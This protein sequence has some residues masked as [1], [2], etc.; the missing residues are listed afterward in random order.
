MTR[1]SFITALAALFCFV[2]FSPA[3]RP[4]AAQSLADL[5]RAGRAA[6]EGGA[7][8][9]SVELKSG[10][11]KGLPQWT[12]VL[13][14]VERERVAFDRCTA[15]AT[16]CT[17]AILRNWRSII[18]SAAKLPRKDRVKAVNDFFN[19]WPYKLDRELYGM[20]EYWATPKEFMTRSGDCEDYSIAKYFALRKLGFAKEELR[21]VILMDE[22]RGIGHSVLAIYVENDILILDS[23]SNLIV[24]HTRYKQYIPQYSMNET[25]RWAHIGGFKKNKTPVYRGLLAGKR[26]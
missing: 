1:R 21:I 16:A 19:R 8:F 9:G 23:L 11:L 14:S 18:T 12:R 26:N 13:R 25:T 3:L 6:E 4:A 15:D 10:S 24:S 5:V 2:V 7:L 20:S 22:I 17:T